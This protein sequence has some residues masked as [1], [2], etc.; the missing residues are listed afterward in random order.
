[1]DITLFSDELMLNSVL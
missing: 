1:M